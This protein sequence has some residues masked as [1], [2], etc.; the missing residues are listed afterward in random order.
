MVNQKRRPGRAAC[1]DDDGGNRAL[2]LS[3]S[4]SESVRNLYTNFGRPPGAKPPV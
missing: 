2:S 4:T 1:D 3:R